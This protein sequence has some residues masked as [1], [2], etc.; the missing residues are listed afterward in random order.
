MTGRVNILK[1]IFEKIAK[2]VKIEVTGTKKRSFWLFYT[3]TFHKTTFLGP[4]ASILTFLQFSQKCAWL[5]KSTL[6]VISSF[7]KFF[8][9]QTSRTRFFFNCWKV[10]IFPIYKSIILIFSLN[11]LVISFYKFCRKEILSN[12]QE[13][14]EDNI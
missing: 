14:F 4:V 13:N 6:P 8:V 9:A 1:R 5:A 12:H 2:K 10:N 3:K 7:M 11:L